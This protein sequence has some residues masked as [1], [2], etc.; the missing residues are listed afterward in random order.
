MHVN[1][2]AVSFCGLMLALTEVCIVLGSV[3]ESN[4]LFLLAAASY[5]V[6]IVIRELGCRT[7]GAFYLA[8]VLLGLMI[9]PNK[10]YVCSYSAMGLYILLR[11]VLWRRIGKMPEHRNRK[12]TFLLGKVTVFNVIYLGI[13]TVGCFV[14]HHQPD[15]WLMMGI[16]VVGQI[17]FVVYDMAYEYLISRVWNRYRR[18]IQP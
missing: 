8:G 5:L 7:G 14:L 1:A 4:T 10:I 11:E 12:N 6:G 16:F 2:K 17:G 3:I 9:A 13:L 15:G 18:K